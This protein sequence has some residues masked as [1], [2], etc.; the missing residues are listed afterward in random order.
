M[1]EQDDIRVAYQGAIDM[2]THEGDAVWARFNVVLVANSIILLA[3]TASTQTPPQ[4]FDVVLP[5]AGITLC[6]TW[7]V[8]MKRGFTYEIYYVIAARML[9]QKLAN[10][11]IQTLTNGKSMSEGEVVKLN[12]EKL[13]M[14]PLAKLSARFTVYVV[15]GV[16]IAAY[17]FLLFKSVPAL[18]IGIL[19]Y[20][21][22]LLVD[23]VA[24]LV[25]IARA[26]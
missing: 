9:E 15:I 12:G 23:R 19:I 14:S 1:L 18:I 2:A 10:G 20:I 13:Q 7:L 11:S 8:L 21:L 22:I 24:L 25:S 3:L 26:K 4:Y 6:A 16:F 5:V 17:V